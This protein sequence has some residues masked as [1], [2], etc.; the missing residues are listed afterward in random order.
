M[1]REALIT[2]IDGASSAASSAAVSN[3]NC[4]LLSVQVSGT[5]STGKIKI[6]GKTD[7]DASEWTDLAFYDK[8]TLTA[9]EGSDGITAKGIYDANIAGLLLVRVDVVSVTGG[10]V[11]V[12]GSFANTSVN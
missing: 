8:S 2:M 12:I 3:S 7:P 4:D 10:N 5:F 9:T 1:K 11:T 6:Q